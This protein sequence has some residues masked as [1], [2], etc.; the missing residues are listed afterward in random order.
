MLGSDPAVSP[1]FYLPVNLTESFEVLVRKKKEFFLWVYWVSFSPALP[2]DGQDMF[3]ARHC[4]FWAPGS[5]TSP[6]AFLTMKS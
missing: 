1:L 6:C 3:L 5:G 2:D 4:L